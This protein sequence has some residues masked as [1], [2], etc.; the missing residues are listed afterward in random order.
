MFPEVFILFLHALPFIVLSQCTCGCFMNLSQMQILRR[1]VLGK[2][3]SWK[4]VK[5][6]FGKNDLTICCWNTSWSW[7]IKRNLEQQYRKYYKKSYLKRLL[8]MIR[9]IKILSLMISQVW[10]RPNIFFPGINVNGI[11]FETL[12]RWNPPKRGEGAYV[13][14]RLQPVRQQEELI[15]WFRNWNEG[16]CKDI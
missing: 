12:P 16:A 3:N 6:Y 5:L 15:S 10:K 1:R 7:Q 9:K 11:T 14:K 8:Q 2:K 4:I 13:I